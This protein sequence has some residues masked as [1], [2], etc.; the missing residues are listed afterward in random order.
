MMFVHHPGAPLTTDPNLPDAALIAVD[1]RECDGRGQMVL[2]ADTDSRTHDRGPHA[3]G[4]EPDKKHG[5]PFRAP[6]VTSQLE[7][8][9]LC[10]VYL[11]CLPLSVA[12]CLA[13]GDTSPT[14]TSATDEMKTDDLKH[15]RW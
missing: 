13:K 14:V 10:P 8:V 9:F 5:V 15:P 2:L 12:G 3:L 7:C 6:Q 11:T 4:G 1:W